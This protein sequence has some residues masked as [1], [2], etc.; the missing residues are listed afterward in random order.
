MGAS[1]PFPWSDDV[2]LAPVLPDDPLLQLDVEE[3]EEEEGQKDQDLTHRWR[4]WN[5]IIAFIW[6]AHITQVTGCREQAAGLQECSLSG[7]HRPS[8]D[9]VNSVL[10]D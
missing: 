6:S 10:V 3:E 7:T 9:E 2:Y 1:P 4:N 5:S 8:A